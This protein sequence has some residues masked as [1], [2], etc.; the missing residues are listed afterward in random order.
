MIERC[1]THL[2]KV[3]VNEKIENK[4]WSKGYVEYNRVTTVKCS[5]CEYEY[6]INCEH[7]TYTVNKK[8]EDDNTITTSL[9]R[10]QR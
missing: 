6:V 1:L 9:R 3:D 10:E 7:V 2:E 8:Y 5:Y 4:T